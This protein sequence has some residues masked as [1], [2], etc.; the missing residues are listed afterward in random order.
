MSYILLVEDNQGNADMT[1]RILESAGY[2]VQH[3]LRGFDGSRLA[4][5]ERPALV[6]MDFDLPDVNG[7]TLALIMR[8][9]LGDQNAPPIV[10]LT[11]K[12]GD[13]E[14]KLAERFG[15]AGFIS[16]PFLPEQLLGVIGK[17]LHEPDKVTTDVTKV[18]E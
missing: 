12:T 10:A 6:L 5:A 7:R 9:Q 18:K 14:V 2:E 17:L 1:I 3:V 16:K 8:K 15:F 11:A 13:V 4:R